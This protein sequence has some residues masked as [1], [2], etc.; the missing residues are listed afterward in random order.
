MPLNVIHET[1]SAF[2]EHGRY[3]GENVGMTAEAEVTVPTTADTEVDTV[4]S[5]DAQFT[6]SVLVSFVF[7]EDMSTDMPT[8][9]L[10]ADF[11]HFLGIFPPTRM[12]F[13][14]SHFSE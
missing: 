5:C 6:S 4:V 12:G 2:D 13:M 10:L 14:K 1:V 8:F 11:S 9:P 3:I 7:Y